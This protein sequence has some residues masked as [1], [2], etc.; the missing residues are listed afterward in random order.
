MAQKRLA[1]MKLEDKE[2]LK[3]E[4]AEGAK[5]L[6]KESVR[7]IFPR[8]RADYEMLYAKVENWRK[9]EIK[10]ISSMKTDA[11]KKAEFC[12]LLKKEIE[13]L[14]TIERYRLELKKEKLAK[15]E[16]SILEKVKN[17]TH[18]HSSLCFLSLT[19]WCSDLCSFLIYYS[20]II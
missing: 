9:A 17:I 15:K 14:N 20:V 6:R 5:H 19:S 10:R 11:P 1:N 8:T 18:E 12:L 4:T 3:W 2:H 13:C 16:L 7:K